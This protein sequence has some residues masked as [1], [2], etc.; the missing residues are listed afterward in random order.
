MHRYIFRIDGTRGTH[1]DYAIEA[2][3]VHEARR[4]AQDNWRND[5]TGEAILR[6]ELD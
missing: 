1:R 3:D 5:T 6:I 2:P 4:R